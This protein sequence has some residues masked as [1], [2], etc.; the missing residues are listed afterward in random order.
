MPDSLPI[1][2]VNSIPSAPKRNDDANKGDCGRAMIVSGS[3]GMSGAACL[4]GKA[5]LRGGAGL[6]TVAVPVGILNIVST[7]EPSY[8][9]MGLTEDDH[10]RIHQAATQQLAQSL[11]HQ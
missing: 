11:P 5:A 1:Q 4:A 10:G 7:Y 8:M 2:L 9:T 3:R 6:V